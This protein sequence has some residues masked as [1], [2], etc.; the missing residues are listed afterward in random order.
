MEFRINVIIT[1][2]TI[3]AATTTITI[4]I[5]INRCSFIA[6]RKSKDYLMEYVKALRLDMLGRSFVKLA[7]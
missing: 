2:I 1:T 3:N 7:Y 5:A 4:T 6:F